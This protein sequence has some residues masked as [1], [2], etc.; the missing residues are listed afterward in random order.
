MK[1][2]KNC[3]RNKI[4]SN[5]ELQ[6]YFIFLTPSF[7]N[8]LKS[9]FGM[10]EFFEFSFFFNFLASWKIPVL[11]VVPGNFRIPVLG[12]FFSPWR[13]HAHRGFF[14]GVLQVQASLLSFLTFFSHLISLSLPLVI[15]FSC[16]SFLSVCF[17]AHSP[18]HVASHVCQFL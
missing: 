1:Q 6:K 17:G 4:I 14:S 13:H 8:M 11:N 12:F 2:I 18:S 16:C 15:F 7:R 9:S 5:L 3:F 10:L